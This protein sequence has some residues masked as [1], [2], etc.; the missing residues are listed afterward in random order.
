[1]AI[2]KAAVKAGRREM[3]PYIAEWRKTQR[4]CD[5]DLEAE[6]AAE[7]ARLEHDY[8]RD[9]LARLVAAGGERIEETPA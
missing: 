3:D 6:A 1:V 8:T 9:V 4:A 2:D 5:D 7:A